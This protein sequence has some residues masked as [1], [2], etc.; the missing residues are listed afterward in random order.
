M[1]LNLPIHNALL[2]RGLLNSREEMLFFVGMMCRHEFLPRETVLYEIGRVGG[3]D[4]GGLLVDAVV[5]ADD[6][7]VA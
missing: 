2:T 5:A 4:E 7:V 1:F 6:G 3:G